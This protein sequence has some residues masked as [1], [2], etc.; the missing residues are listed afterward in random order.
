MRMRVRIGDYTKIIM[1][2]GS[3]FISLLFGLNFLGV[4]DINVNAVSVGVTLLVLGAVIVSEIYLEDRIFKIDVLSGVSLTIAILSF[5]MGGYILVQGYST[6][7][8]TFQGVL[9][10]LFILDAV[11]VAVELRK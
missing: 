9:G 2:C 1:A 7:P 4:L 5:L 3:I 10:L 6:L 8:Q 11:I